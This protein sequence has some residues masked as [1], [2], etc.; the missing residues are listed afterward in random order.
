MK[1]RDMNDNELL[2][3]ISDGIE[4]AY[5]MLFKKYEPLI[6]S[7][8][9]KMFNYAKGT[10]IELSDLIQEGMVGLSNAVNSY[11][12]NKDAT[13]YTYAK[14]CI[15]RNI[16]SYIIC[17]KRVKHKFLN[18]SVSYEI[19]ED[20]YKFESIMMDNSFNPEDMIILKEEENLLI[21]NA[22]KRLT[23]FEISV[24]ELKQSG[25]NYKEIAR[26]LDKSDKSIDNALT[27]IKQK[28][29]EELV[30]LNG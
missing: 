29:K 11:D 17:Q 26:I 13:F 25:L 28:L 15:E 24:F 14:T 12:T 18:E 30:K 8:S 21:N 9:N 10:C 16:I 23:D 1:Y 22:K 6:S 3:Y 7:I 19:D 4:E 27:R 20:S 5:D 2:Y